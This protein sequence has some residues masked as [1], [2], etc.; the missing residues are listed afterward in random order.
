LKAKGWWLACQAQH[1]LLCV[2]PLPVCFLPL[3]SAKQNAANV[4]ERVIS[5]GGRLGDENIRKVVTALV[6]S[7][8]DRVAAVKVLL[9]CAASTVSLLAHMITKTPVLDSLRNAPD[10]PWRCGRWQR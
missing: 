7:E 2:W 6:V 3:Q 4:H 1:Q 8:Y 10:G 5:V 9:T